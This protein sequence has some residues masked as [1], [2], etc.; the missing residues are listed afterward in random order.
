[1]PG[2]LVEYRALL[3]ERMTEAAF[4]RDK[5]QV[6]DV[7]DLNS[8]L[9]LMEAANPLMS[10]VP[11]RKVSAI[12]AEPTKPAPARKLPDGS[13]VVWEPIKATHIT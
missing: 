12:A 11:R 2:L 6:E 3:R 9:R 13:A 8:R 10:G 5:I 4:H 1:M 7:L